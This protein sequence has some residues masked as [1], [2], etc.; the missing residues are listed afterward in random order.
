MKIIFFGTPEFAVH[1]L[2]RIHQEN[3]EICAVVTVPDKASGR[4]LQIR[5]SAVKEFALSHNLEILQPENLKEPAFIQKLESYKA[6]L[7]VVV[8]FRKLPIEVWTLPKKGTINLHASLLPDYRGA[9]PINW[10]IIN[11]EQ[12]SGVTTFFIND[13]IDEGEIL[14]A[15][16][17][18]IDGHFNAGML[19]DK[20]ADT[21]ASLLV[22][23]IRGIEKNILLPTP[24]P[25]LLSLNKAPKISKEDCRINWNL[26]AVKI[27]NLIRG[28]S[29]YPGAFTF[30]ENKVLKIY[31]ASFQ[32]GSHKYKYGTLFSDG[33]TYLHVAVPDGFIHVLELQAEG[34]KKLTI[35]DFL[36][37]IQLPK[38]TKFI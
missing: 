8:A 16:G 2:K 6:D 3:I 9:A 33:K 34:K 15:E 23:T 29:P 37:G 4:G 22:K 26:P 31:A 21:G 5:Y 19:H 13:K 10:V 38:L 36:N 32:T 28:L 12:K 17:V 27:N 35:H 1:S 30:Y 20:L 7:F 25:S 11:G 14:L 24:Q 18:H